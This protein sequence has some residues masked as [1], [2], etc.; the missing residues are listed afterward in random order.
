MRKTLIL[1]AMMGAMIAPCAMAAG[2]ARHVV[3]MVWDGMRPDFVSAEKTPTLWQMAREGVWFENHHAVYLS[4]TEVNGTAIATGSYPEHGGIIANREYRPRLDAEKIVHTEE[5]ATV[6]DGDRLSGGHY[7]R[8]PTMAELIQQ[9][10]M[11][12]V[13]AGAKGIAL[14]QDRAER[15]AGSEDA[16]LFAGETLPPGLLEKIEAV[17]GKFPKVA[18]TNMTRNDWTTK[19]VTDLLW[20]DGVPQFTLIWLNQPDITQHE[21]GPG[22]RASLAAMKNAD[23]NLARVLQALDEKGM[24][25]KTDV[26][27]VSDHGFS[28]VLAVVDVADS[29]RAAGFSAQREFKS[30]PVKND[31][32]VAGNGGSVLFYVNGHDPKLIRD[33]VNFLQNW[34][35]T[36]VIFTRQPMEGT[37]TMD[38]AGVQSPDGPDVMISMRWIA[39]RNDAGTPGMMISD[40]Y[41]YGPGQGLH[42][43]IGRYDM[44]NTLVAA[45]PDFRSAVVDRLPSGN[46]DIAP[47]VLWIL[48]VKQPKS[49]DGRVLGE[50]M[51]DTNVKLKSYEPTH[52]EASRESEKSVWRQYLDVSEVNGVRYIDEGNGYQTAK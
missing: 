34:P 38:Q 45:G 39:D 29:L 37:F 35:H 3:V 25:D 12:T 31:I 23:A 51:W 33:L 52:L 10:G 9:K 6:R 28:T 5:V 17:N 14:L 7:L 20:K 50:A 18:D 11:K 49:M 42:G 41:V 44:H 19:A 1:L 36:G 16:T 2:R 24:R 8:A 48:G 32:M 26:M 43:T 15:K 21:T 22:S 46:V 4:A 27:V 40:A 13:I 47:T 30:P